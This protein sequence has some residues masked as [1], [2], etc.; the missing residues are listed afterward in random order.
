MIIWTDLRHSLENKQAA[1]R[2]FL[3]RLWLYLID[4]KIEKDKCNL[5]IQ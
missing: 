2:Y 4:D 3:N 1:V 5:I